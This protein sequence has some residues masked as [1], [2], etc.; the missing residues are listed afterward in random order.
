MQVK[1]PVTMKS[2]ATVEFE[3]EL[4]AEAKPED[5]RETETNQASF[6]RPSMEEQVRETLRE[7]PLPVANTADRPTRISL[8]EDLT[9]EVDV[10][11]QTVD[12]TVEGKKEAVE[13]LQD[14]GRELEAELNKDGYDLDSFGQ[15]RSPEERRSTLYRGRRNGGQ[16]D[17]DSTDGPKETAPPRRPLQD[18]RGRHVNIIV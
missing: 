2:A 4:S 9:L 8:D 15:R 14:L 17:A 7:E 16:P 10:Q 3:A 5:L 1:R 11:G 6:D 12:V 13:P 18:G